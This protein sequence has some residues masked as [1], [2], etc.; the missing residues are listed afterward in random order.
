MA[1]SMET[2][3]KLL[4]A[5]TICAEPLFGWLAYHCSWIIKWPPNGPVT[6]FLGWGTVVFLFLCFSAVFWIA[7]AVSVYFWRWR[8]RNPD[9][10]DLRLH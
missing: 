2:S 10:M 8:S 7:I 6:Y 9:V 4:V 1:D 3:K 5:T